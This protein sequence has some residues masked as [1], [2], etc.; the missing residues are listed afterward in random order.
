[1]FE[2]VLKSL[3]NLFKPPVTIDYPLRPAEAAPAAYR[4]KVLVEA[5][6]CVGCSTCA[7][8]CVSNAIRLDDENEGIRLTVW[9]SK[10]TFCGLCGFYCPTGAITISNEWELHHRNDRKYAQSTTI[11]AKYKICVDCGSKLMVPKENVMAAEII[12]RQRQDQASHPRCEACRRKMKAKQ[13]L[14][15]T[16]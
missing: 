3:G 5:D 15:A 7:Q 11:L 8:V 1:M 6:A 4:G 9:H 2:F 14:E 16:L 10:C 13:I 12:G